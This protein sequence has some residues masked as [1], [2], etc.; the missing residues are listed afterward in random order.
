VN[1]NQITSYRS[2]DNFSAFLS[3]LIKFNLFPT[4]I[5]QIAFIRYNKLTTPK[6]LTLIFDGEWTKVG[7]EIPTK[8][9]GAM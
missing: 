3:Y 8:S 1:F 2:L 4:I 6:S 9:E 7:K 5:S